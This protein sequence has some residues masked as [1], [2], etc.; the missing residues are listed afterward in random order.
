VRRETKEKKVQ[1]MQGSFDG[2]A[3]YFLVDF[4]SM[5][6]TKS[7]ELRKLLKKNSY[8]F[9]VVKNRLAVKAL[10]EGLPP[11]LKPSF[12]RPTG[13]AFAAQNPIGLARLLKDFSAQGKVLSIKAGMIEGRYLAPERFEELAGLASKDDLLAKIGYLLASPLMRFQRTWQAPL[14]NLGRLLSQLKH[15]K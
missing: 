12:R 14:I 7:V 1:E 10:G 2:N 3:S 8:S 15:N 11:E 5:P 9:R 13:I 6:V 4:K